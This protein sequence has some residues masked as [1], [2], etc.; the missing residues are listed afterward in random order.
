MQLLR[1]LGWCLAQP[2]VG[3]R[4]DDS[5]PC[6]FCVQEAVCPLRLSQEPLS[7]QHVSHTGALVP[8]SQ[9]PA[10]SPS[11]RAYPVQE[12]VLAVVEDHGPLCWADL[13]VFDNC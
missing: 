4:P 2:S 3:L 5:G 7:L 10:L 9:R 12:D 6:G 13:A 11:S 1:S 8:A